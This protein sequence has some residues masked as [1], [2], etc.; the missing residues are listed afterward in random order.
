MAEEISPRNSTCAELAKTTTRS[1][2][3]A[4]PIRLDQATQ[5]LADGVGRDGCSESA[6]AKGTGQAGPGTRV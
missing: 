6:A 2:A 5:D 3:T 1:G 4:A